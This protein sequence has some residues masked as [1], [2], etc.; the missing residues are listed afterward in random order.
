MNPRKKAPL[1]QEDLQITAVGLKR[2]PGDKRPVTA[3]TTV[4][5][6]ETFPKTPGV[7]WRHADIESDPYFIMPSLSM[8]NSST[9]L[10]SST[11]SLIK[12]PDTV[13]GG[14]RL[15][16]AYDRRK[17]LTPKTVVV[18]RIKHIAGG[19]NNVG[20]GESDT[21]LEEQEM[22]TY[23][24]TVPLPPQAQ[25]SPRASTIDNAGEPQSV[26][27]SIGNGMNAQIHPY[28]DDETGDL[29]ASEPTYR[30][31]STQASDRAKSR[32]GRPGSSRDKSSKV[33]IID[34]VQSAE[35]EEA[36]QQILDI[37]RT[38]SSDNSLHDLQED[39][40][41]VFT[42]LISALTGSNNIDSISAL[43][44]MAVE[45]TQTNIEQSSDSPVVRERP[46]SKQSRALREL[47]TA[48]TNAT[49]S[50]DQLN[51]SER[52]PSRALLELLTNIAASASQSLSLDGAESEEHV[53]RPPSAKLI[54]II[55][56]IVNPADFDVEMKSSS[57][58][59][60][61][62]DERDALETTSVQMIGESAESDVHKVLV[63]PQSASSSRAR[64]ESAKQLMDLLSHM[65][66]TGQSRPNT[67]G[68]RPTSASKLVE[69]ISKISA[70]DEVR[71]EIRE[72]V[73]PFSARDNQNDDN[74]SSSSVTASGES[75]GQTSQTSLSSDN[76]SKRQWIPSGTDKDGL[77]KFLSPK[78]GSKEGSLNSVTKS[79]TTKAGRSTSKEKA[80][81]ATKRSSKTKSGDKVESSKSKK[82]SNE[83]IEN[84]KG[85]FFAIINKTSS[86]ANLQTDVSAIDPSATLQPVATGESGKSSKMGSSSKMIGKRDKTLAITDSGSASTLESSADASK[87]GDVKDVKKA[88]KKPMKPKYEPISAVALFHA[89]YPKTDRKE[90]DKKEDI[91]FTLQTFDR[92]TDGV[93]D[94]SLAYRFW[95]FYVHLKDSGDMLPK[96]TRKELS[97]LYFDNV[98]MT[99][100]VSNELNMLSRVEYCRQKV[101]W[102]FIRFLALQSKKENITRNV[103]EVFASVLIGEIPMDDGYEP[104]ARQLQSFEDMNKILQSEQEGPLRLSDMVAFD[105]M[106]NY[107]TTIFVNAVSQV[108]TDPQDAEL[109]S[110]KWLVP[111]T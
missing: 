32:S 86:Q 42:N 82:S 7:Q 81:D 49:G 83:T 55:S 73:R 106:Q 12:R 6:V 62:E 21:L 13:A 34:E 76:A 71:E 64:P 50:K 88:V 26:V 105:I 20:S 70:S 52:P 44:E 33:T 85:E 22:C 27:L 5:N 31:P 9:S 109:V 24:A 36:A 89:N 41:G 91:K 38:L 111:K 54:D 58:S 92:C 16:S 72:I 40:E 51:I 101:S 77:K 17:V 99:D 11:A 30:R 104:E 84:G 1:K 102:N 67:A 108:A 39:P 45:N 87:P 97:V 47:L 74:D 53:A 48:V 93:I 61:E 59:I 15:R 18:G 69:F 4:Y 37:I 96:D 23:F 28:E 94:N 43:T 103:A 2:K 90:H 110:K 98:K 56:K 60:E 57:E 80:R 95:L 107:G 25:K 78:D 35:A 8:V 29:F 79:R 68:G 65:S 10:L 19:K 3:T 14:E 46:Q 75:I 63:K 66:S 100:V